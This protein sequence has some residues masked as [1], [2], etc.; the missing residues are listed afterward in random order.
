M[1]YTLSEDGDDQEKRYWSYLEPVFPNYELFWREFIIPLTN[2]PSNIRIRKDVDEKLER[3]AMAHY[4]AYYHLGRAYEI[5]RERQYPLRDFGGEVLFH[6]G[7]AIDMVEELCFSI[8]GI[9]E[10]LDGTEAKMKTEDDLVELAK[11][12][13][14]KEYTRQF[15][16]WIERHKPV[17]IRVH[18]K[19]SVLRQALSKHA[20]G[21]RGTAGEI[22]SLRNAVA[23]N[24][25]IGQIVWDDQIFIPRPENLGKY[26]LWTKVFYEHDKN[27]FL[28]L[29]KHLDACLRELSEKIN[30]LWEHLISW[31]RELKK[32]PK[33][34]HLEQVTQASYIGEPMQQSGGSVI[35]IMGPQQ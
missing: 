6:M 12:F 19:T 18:D 8:E 13:F 10:Q 15:K 24:P 28:P 27:D 34:Q 16:N 23:H 32:H 25:L 22:R 1:H 2:R 7:V 5:L 9:K 3:M 31:M 30:F 26:S 35:L 17:S 4:S 29:E 33:Y 20:S 21:F 14:K 11:K